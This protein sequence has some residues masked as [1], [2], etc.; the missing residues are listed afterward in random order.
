MYKLE[1]QLTAEFKNIITK[2]QTPF[3]VSALA[4]EFNYSSGRT[5]VIAV[6]TSEELIAFEAKLTNW[7]QALN[8]SYRNSSFAHYSYVVTPASTAIRALKKSREFIKRGVGLCSIDS[9]GI[10]LEI[11]ARKKTPIQPWI[12]NSAIGYITANQYA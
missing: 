6:T 9:S 4:L 8:Q 2:V 10:K 11:P 7:Q 3:E 12:T 5:D 1:I